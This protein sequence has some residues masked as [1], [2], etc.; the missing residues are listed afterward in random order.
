M[1]I[2]GL[3][4]RLAVLL[5]NQRLVHNLADLYRLTP[6]G[7]LGLEGFAEKRAQRPAG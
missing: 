7:L 4:S 1:D 2:E 6:H 5:V 3:G